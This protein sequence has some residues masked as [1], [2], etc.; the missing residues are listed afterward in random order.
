MSYLQSTS[1]THHKRAQ[2][3]TRDEESCSASRDA[4][5][6]GWRRTGFKN[7]PSMRGTVSLVPPLQEKSTDDA[8]KIRSAQK[9]RAALRCPASK[10]LKVST[11]QGT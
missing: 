4:S 8:L 9:C 5:V 7:E 3:F 6:Q 1:C 2:K 10:N 11:A